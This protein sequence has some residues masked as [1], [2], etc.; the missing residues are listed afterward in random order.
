MNN[1]RPSIYV[2]ETYGEL[3]LPA[4]EGDVGYDVQTVSHPKI[5]GQQ[6]LSDNLWYS[7]DYIEYDLGIRLDGLQPAASR[8]EDVYTLIFP[9]SS[10]SNYN[11][12]LANSVGVVDSGYRG[13]VKV[14]F[15]YVFQPEDLKATQFGNIVGRVNLEKIYKK[16]DKVCQLVFKSHFHPLIEVLDELEDSERQGDGFGS[17]GL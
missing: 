14:R 11:L 9:R 6:A 13:S 3:L 12:L 10:I 5:V 1:S 7:V 2:E 15:K 16:G 8:H 4:K 17:T